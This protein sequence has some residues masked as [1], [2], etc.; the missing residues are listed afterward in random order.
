MTQQLVLAALP[1]L[2]LFA[3]IAAP[4]FRSWLR[5]G[6]NAYEAPQDSIQSFLHFAVKLTLGGYAGWGLLMALWGPEALDVHPGPPVLAGLGYA[7]CFAGLAVTMLA[8]WQMGRSWRIG[9]NSEKTELVTHGL[10]RFS[11]NPIYLGLLLM[12]GGLALA[13]PSGWTALG[14]AL[15]HVL[16]GLQCRVEEAHLLSVHGEPYRAW[17]SKVGRL[18]PGVGAL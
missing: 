8:Q 13:A 10:Y 17:A 5:Y 7:L 6:L 9:L 18:L 11:R 14:Y 2:A 4:M 16:F 3:V 1:L 12:V 15:C